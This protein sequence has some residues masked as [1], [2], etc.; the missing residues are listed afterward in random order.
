MKNLFRKICWLLPNVITC[1]RYQKSR[2][3]I[4]CKMRKRD[5]EEQTR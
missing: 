5:L 2:Q 4:K 3:L 1:H